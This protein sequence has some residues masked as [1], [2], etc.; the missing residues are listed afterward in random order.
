MII[1]KNNENKD[2]YFISNI[3]YMQRKK[4]IKQTIFRDFLLLSGIFI[5]SVALLYIISLILSLS[6]NQ[7]IILSPY[8]YLLYV[9]SLIIICVVDIISYLINMKN[10]QHVSKI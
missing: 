5:V 7:S 4:Y 6:L 10:I 3:F 2:V 9:I 8:I 1:T